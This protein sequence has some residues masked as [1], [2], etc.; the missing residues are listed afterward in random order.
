MGVV[1]R[2]FQMVADG[3]GL[4]AVKR[5][6][7]GEGVPAPSGGSRWSR[8][9]LRDFIRKDAYFPFNHSE[10]TALVHLGV[11]DRLDPGKPHGVV[12]TGRHNWRVIERVRLPDGEGCRN[13]RKHTEKP[14]EEWIGLPVPGSGVPRGVAERARRN[15]EL[16]VPAPPKKGRR[17]WDLSGG[18]LR[19]AECGRAVRGHTVS[20]RGRK[21][22]YYY[23][24]CPSKVEEYWKT[25]C[26]NRNHRAADLE[27]RVRGFV[28]RLIENPDTLREQ[29]EQQARAARESKPWVRDAGGGNYP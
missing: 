11:A 10:V 2:I 3:E 20:P 19:C 18:V 6:L 13:L 21:R 23:Y 26:P 4:M 14:K 25:A 27:A 1:R 17:F 22:S 7:E 24:V 15:V 8:S 5:A 12:W 9:T 29:V 16:R 28:T